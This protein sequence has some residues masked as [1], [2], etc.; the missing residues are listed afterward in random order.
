MKHVSED[1][2]FPAERINVKA[3]QKMLQKI[4]KLLK[5][6]ENNVY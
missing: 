1:V 2:K 5:M 3:K 6:T 4:Q